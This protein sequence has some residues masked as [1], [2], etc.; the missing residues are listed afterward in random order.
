MP[1]GGGGGGGGVY[2]SKLPDVSMFP[3]VNKKM[4]HPTLGGGGGTPI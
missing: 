1:G 3:F 4:V 2:T